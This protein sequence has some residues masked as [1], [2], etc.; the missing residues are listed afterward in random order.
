MCRV[1]Q[2]FISMVGGVLIGEGFKEYGPASIELV[3]GV[4][5][6]GITFLF[7]VIQEHISGDDK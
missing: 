4:L 6:S 1:L 5:V 2:I 3:A 7:A